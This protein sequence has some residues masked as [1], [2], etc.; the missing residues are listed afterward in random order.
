MDESADTAREPLRLHPAL[1]IVLYDWLMSLDLDS[2]PVGIVLIR[3][4]T[5]LLTAIQADTRAQYS[6]AA[7]IAQARE[8]VVREHS[9]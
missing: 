5:D 9:G 3:S 6:T 4:L 2:V 8:H 1:V 7:D